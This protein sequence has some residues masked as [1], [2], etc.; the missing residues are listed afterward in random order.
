MNNQL[1]YR[2]IPYME[3]MSKFTIAD[4]AKEWLE[5]ERRKGTRCLEVKV[6]NGN[7]YVYSSTTEYDQSKKGAR[8]KSTYV[9]TL[10]LS[11]GEAVFSPKKKNSRQRETGLRTIRESGPMRLLDRCAGE[12]PTHLERR[13]PTD[14]DSAYALSLVRCVRHVPLKSANAAWEKY[15]PVRHLL[16][17][18]SEKTLSGVLE[19]IGSDR[20][21]Q[22]LFFRDTL[23]EGD[24]IAFDLTEFFSTSGELALAEK[25][26]N[27]EHDDRKQVN[28]AMACSIDTGEPSYV[29]ALPGSVRDV[30]SLCACLKEMGI[31]GLVLVADRGL[32]SESNLHDISASE[33]EYAIPVRRNS[34]YYEQVETVDT[35]FFFWNEKVIRFGKAAAS[36][37]KLLYRFVNDEMRMSEERNL[38][39]K[40]K[41]GALGIEDYEKTRGRLGNMVV[42]SSLD[43]DP[44]WIYRLYKRRDRIE[45]RF[46]TLFSVLESDATYMR[47]DDR[48]RGHLFVAFLSLKIISRL[49]A[50]IRDAG[51][52]GSMS[53][54]DVLLAYSKA[55][56]VSGE[57]GDV[58]YEV[59]AKTE[60]LDSKL[61]FNIFPILRS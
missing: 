26:R 43:R 12:I 53:V 16:P 4:W 60:K 40:V 44:E 49:E 51:L 24:G 20:E 32:Y 23:P 31:E 28:I 56:V 13:F 1:Y 37:G 52:L 35:D 25:G 6:S 45:K 22:A 19:R 14:W 50:R 2:Y 47:D 21:A 18:M 55:Y 7:H 61:G 5:E 57:G 15:E 48:L 33:M 54:E 39:K 58:D 41:E 46:R 17:P 10:K 38:L 11:N 30:K 8:K 29:R 9:G 42:V 59:P 36:D 27:P 3:Y 34:V